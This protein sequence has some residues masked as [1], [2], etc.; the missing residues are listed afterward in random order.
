MS[1]PMPDILSFTR[2]GHA[3]FDPRTIAAEIE[4]LLPDSVGLLPSAANPITPREAYALRLVAELIGALHVEA[5]AVG[6]ARKFVFGGVTIDTRRREVL[7]DGEIVPLTPRQY[8]LLLALAMEEGAPVSRATLRRTIWKNSI[9][10]DSRAIDQTI[11][12]LRRKLEKTPARPRYILKS[13]KLG[14]R[15]DGRWVAD[16]AA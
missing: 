11:L 3:P 2:R 6:P 10:P 13:S 14:Y 8:D 4:T 12:E 9:G 5:D 7:S 1:N 16:K 15:L